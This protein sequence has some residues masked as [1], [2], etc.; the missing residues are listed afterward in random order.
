MPRTKQCIS[1]STKLCDRWFK[2]A[3]LLVKGSFEISDTGFQFGDDALSSEKSSGFGF[4]DLHLQLFYLKNKTL[5]EEISRNIRKSYLFLQRSSEGVNLGSVLLFL[6]E[7]VHGSGNI[8]KYSNKPVKKGILNIPAWHA[9][10][11]HRRHATHAE[12]EKGRHEQWRVRFRAS[13]WPAQ[14]LV[15]ECKCVSM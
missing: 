1:L 15:K 5:E 14:F 11:A 4:L 9:E 10:R 2:P 3:G 6:A 12:H 7:L 8:L 13:S